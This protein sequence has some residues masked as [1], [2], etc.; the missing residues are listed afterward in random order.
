MREC[1]GCG[2]RRPEVHFGGHWNN[3]DRRCRDCRHQPGAYDHLMGQLHPA[4]QAGQQL[5]VNQGEPSLYLGTA[6]GKLHAS[7]V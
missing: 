5:A 3:H 1:A 7:I 6:S 4:K 2:E